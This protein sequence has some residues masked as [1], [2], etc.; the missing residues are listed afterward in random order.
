MELQEFQI[1]WHGINVAAAS[2]Q[3]RAA[4]QQTSIEP[5]VI[6]EQFVAAERA[7]VDE[8]WTRG[9]ADRRRRPTAVRW[10]LDSQSQE[11]G[12]VAIDGNDRRRVL[13]GAGVGAR[14]ANGP[15]RVSR[16]VRP[17]R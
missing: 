11:A 2:E 7:S 17:T 10:L 9:H 4:S 16:V 12:A 6:A 13:R 8:L 15:G 5:R 1:A 14:P 3:L